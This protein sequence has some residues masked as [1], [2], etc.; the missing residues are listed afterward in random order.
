MSI[1][2][3]SKWMGDLPSIPEHRMFDFYN[4]LKAGEELSNKDQLIV[5]NSLYGTFSQHNATFKYLGFAAPFYSVLTR[6]LVKKEHSGWAEYYAFSE[7]ELHA[8]LDPDEYD[9]EADHICEIIKAPVK[10]PATV[11]KK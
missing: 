8:V 1:Y 10:T 11:E 4:R 3:F 9:E 6:F 2:Q 7:K 5:V